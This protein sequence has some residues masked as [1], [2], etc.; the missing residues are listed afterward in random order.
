M[1]AKPPRKPAQARRAGSPVSVRRAVEAGARAAARVRRERAAALRRRAMAIAAAPRVARAR[2][3]PIEPRFTRAAGPKGIGT[4]VAEGDSWFDYLWHDVLNVLESEHGYD[5]ESVARSGDRVEDMAYAGGQLAGFKQVLEKLVRRQELPQA[6]LLSGG[7]NDV[8]GDEFVMLL[9]HA[10]SP[11]PGLNEDVVR[12]VI[13]VR[14]RHA[15]I[16][17]LT[18]ITD[19]CVTTTGH[20]I[21]IIVHGYARPVPDGRGVGAGWP[22]PGLP[23]PWLR[24]GFHR[25]G[26]MDQN[27]NTA[28]VG[29]LIDRFNEMVRRVASGAQFR[30]VRFVDLRR[31]LPNGANYREWWANELHPTRTGFEAVAARFA[32]AI[33]RTSVTKRK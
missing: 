5:I 16:A 25:K 6:V 2:S 33:A 4:L 24:P 32:E 23:G 12:G 1:A 26:L 29:A 18:A 8:V 17:L 13:D 11:H 3:L 21:P 14:I 10:A 15:Y 31:E 28:T 19:L 9:D 27:A 30:H 20:L 7:G 22:V